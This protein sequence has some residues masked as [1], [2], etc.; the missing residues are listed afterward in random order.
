MLRVSNVQNPPDARLVVSRT[1]R[2]PLIERIKAPLG[3]LTER[4]VG[5]VGIKAALVASDQA[6]LYVHGGG[7]AKRWDSCAPEAIV[8]GAGGIFTDLDGVP[9]DYRSADLVLHSGMVVSNP[10]LG[11]RVLSVTRGLRRTKDEG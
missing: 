7:G 3:I 11:E 4:S 9:I 5:S 1:H 2:S 6:D 10:A 8:R